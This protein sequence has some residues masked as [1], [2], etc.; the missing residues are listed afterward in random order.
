MGVSLKTTFCPTL[1]PLFLS[2]SHPPG[3]EKCMFLVPLVQSWLP[4]PPQAVGHEQKPPNPWATMLSP[5]PLKSRKDLSQ[6]G[7]PAST[8]HRCHLPT[9]APLC[10][11][12]RDQSRASASQHLSPDLQC[13]LT[14]EPQ[15]Q[16]HAC[17]VPCTAAL[18]PHGSYIA[19][20]E[21][22]SDPEA[23]ESVWSVH[24]NAFP[25]R[26][27]KTLIFI[28]QPHVETSTRCILCVTIMVFG[29]GK[30]ITHTIVT[31]KFTFILLI[32]RNKCEPYIY[33]VWI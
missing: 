14:A 28:T 12:A 11:S 23:K 9:G 25:G 17:S 16:E 21:H 1:L 7:T 4:L 18:L 15:L 3:T 2:A 31:K 22:S 20:T 27:W 26:I 19:R 6:H 13:A 32:R 5:P 24:S 30:E 8:N 29:G 33:M 10:A